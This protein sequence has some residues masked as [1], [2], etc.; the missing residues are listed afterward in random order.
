MNGGR[1]QSLRSTA[2]GREPIELRA[3]CHGHAG[4]SKAPPREGRQESGCGK[5]R[6]SDSMSETAQVSE[7]TKQAESIP[8]PTQWDWVDRTIWTERM[9]AALGN[10]VKGNKWFSLIDKVYRR[11]DI[12]ARFQASRGASGYFQD[13]YA[14][15]LASLLCDTSSPIRLRY[16]KRTRA[17]RARGCEDD[18]D[19][20]ACAESGRAWCDKPA[21]SDV[22]RG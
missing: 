3:G 9:L 15:H 22:E 12:P 21:G 8:T 1:S 5:D 13:C 10:G 2:S 20:H 18:D 6:R 7:R 14:S 11:S 19:L 17:A 16:S 4:N